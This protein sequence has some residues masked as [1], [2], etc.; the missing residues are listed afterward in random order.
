MT[1]EDKIM[2]M[3]FEAILTA[4]ESGKNEQKLKDENIMLHLKA[5]AE[6]VESQREDLVE[7]RDNT[8]LTN[9]RVTKLENSK[10]DHIIHCPRVNEIKVIEDKYEK[11]RSSIEDLTFVQRHPILFTALI[12]A[13]IFVAIY[14]KSMP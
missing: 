2:S 10:N 7:T 9:G 5:L 3:Q 6:K 14:F 8:R 4:I 11:I 12:I 1:S 13:T